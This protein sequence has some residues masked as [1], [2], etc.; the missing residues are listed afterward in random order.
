MTLRTGEDT[1]NWRRKLYIAL[2]GEIV[3]EEALDLSF[4]RLLMMMSYFLQRKLININTTF[5]WKVFL[6]TSQ[7]T[8]LQLLVSPVVSCLHC[9]PL[10][11][12]WLSFQPFPLNFE[13][14]SWDMYI[15]ICTETDWLHEHQ[16]EQVHCCF[17]QLVLQLLLS[18]Y[19]YNARLLSAQRL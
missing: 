10:T 19:G 6:R 1:V 2:C 16:L 5:A 9:S 18:R 3:L 15:H 8:V 7:R 17:G 13:T 11:S 14:S 12:K 4:D